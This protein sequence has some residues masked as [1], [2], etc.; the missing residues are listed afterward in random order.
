MIADVR[1]RAGW[2]PDGVWSPDGAIGRSERP[3]PG[4][5][6]SRRF[7]LRRGAALALVMAWPI[8]AVAAEPWRFDEA[9][10]AEETIESLLQA[11][12]KTAAHD[13]DPVRRAWARRTLGRAKDWSVAPL[14]EPGLRDASP[15]VRVEALAGVRALLYA[16]GDERDVARSA[17]VNGLRSADPGLRWAATRLIED[18]T[19]HRDEST[20]WNEPALVVGLLDDSETT[21][22]VC[23]AQLRAGES[24]GNAIAAAQLDA[25]LVGSPRVKLATINERSPEELAEGTWRAA[26]QT[27]MADPVREVRVAATLSAFEE[28][29]DGCARLLT[30]PDPVV[31]ATVFSE[32][33]PV[34][35]ENRAKL[36]AQGLSDPDPHVVAA[37]FAYAWENRTPIRGDVAILRR[38]AAE[39][40][41]DRASASA[42]LLWETLAEAAA[43][44]DAL[45]VAPRGDGLD[46]LW[47]SASEFGRRLAEQERAA[48]GA[49][50]SREASAGRDAR[51]AAGSFAIVE[52]LAAS[53]ADPDA[54]VRVASCGVVAQA[55]CWFGRHEPA[56]REFGVGAMWDRVF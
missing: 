13:A 54:R 48:G 39:A 53:L 44:G 17:V 26:L 45:V 35:A 25:V 16:K 49:S 30:D 40:D 50:E 34:L 23:L 20:A 14:L 8:V 52:R 27:N 3:V 33:L 41:D 28:R 24:L 12:R 29:D 9:A 18:F 51:G 11:V 56:F 43:A 31:R 2:A 15:G 21:R 7:A 5:A 4:A 1:S 36:V 46:A 37:A 38:E 42:A 32:R 55:L 22:R 6:F 10:S 19:N 47:P